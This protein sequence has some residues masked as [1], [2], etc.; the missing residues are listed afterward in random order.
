MSYQDL[1][2]ECEIIS[3]Q[4]AV[5]KGEHAPHIKMVLEDVRIDS[6]LIQLAKK[7]DIET[8]LDY[9]PDDLIKDYA[10]GIK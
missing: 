3:N 4:G 8:V 6:L 5:K 7:I 10:K 1:V 9:F 2:I